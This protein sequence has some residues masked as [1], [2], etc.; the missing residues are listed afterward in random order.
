MLNVQRGDIEAEMQ[1]CDA[2]DEILK[3]KGYSFGSLL[4]LDPAGQLRD[5]ECHGIDGQVL[6]RAFSEDAPSFAVGFGS[7]SVDAMRQLHYT[8]S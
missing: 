2:D 8:H 4:A 5:L 1:G 6:E 3:R 7:G